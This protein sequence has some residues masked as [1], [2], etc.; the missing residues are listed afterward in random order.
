MAEN[1]DELAFEQ[2]RITI[3]WGLDADDRPM[4]TVHLSPGPDDVPYIEAA[5]ALAMA[6]ESLP[7]IYAA[8]SDD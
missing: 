1:E 5:G 6:Q 4:H 8:E 7:P 3:A 2:G